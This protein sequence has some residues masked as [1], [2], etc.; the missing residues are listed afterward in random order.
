MKKIM[1]LIITSIFLIG[2]VYAQEDSLEI[3]G[4]TFKVPEEFCGGDNITNGYRYDNNFSII[5]IDEDIPNAIG[6]WAMEY[7]YTNDLK[8]GKHPVRHYCKNNEYVGDNH[9][10]AYFASGKSIYEISWVGKNIT[11][12]IENLIKNTPKS[13]IN[14]DAFYEKL[15]E[16]VKIY[17]LQKIDKLNQEAEYDYL[18]SKYN[19]QNNQKPTHDDT[20]F[21]QIL[22]SHYL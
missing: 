17:K 13:K 6:L 4:I 9:S 19:V 3:N 8:I 5:C 12:D 7:D 14:D 22:L 15:D 20:Q 1:I 10:H 11:N 21:K 16:S 2:C 18:E